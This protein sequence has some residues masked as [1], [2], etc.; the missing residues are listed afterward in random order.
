V[1]A[2]EVVGSGFFGLFLLGL[3]AN[4]AA[5]VDGWSF[6]GSTSQRYGGAPYPFSYDALLGTARVAMTVPCSDGSRLED[7]FRISVP[8]LPPS[9]PG[10]YAQ[11]TT[12]G[13]RIVHEYWLSMNRRGSTVSGRARVRVTFEQDGAVARS[14]D[15][16]SVRY[17]ARDDVFAGDSAPGG[18]YPLALSAR[19]ERGGRRLGSF[20]ITWATQSCPLAGGG[21]GFLAAPTKVPRAAINR[22]GRFRERGSHRVRTSRGNLLVVRYTL[23][24]RVEEFRSRGRRRDLLSGVFTVSADLRE[25]DGSYRIRDCP[26]DPILFEAER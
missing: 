14:C 1:R 21:R 5:A 7:V 8:D 16:S 4:P 2:R 3:C 18:G 17:S 13:G 25:Q 9:G 26:T 24:G 12:D 19:L 15:T 10:V 23:A 11:P 20:L 6:G 22:K